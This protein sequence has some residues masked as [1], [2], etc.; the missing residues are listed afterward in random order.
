MTRIK[1]LLTTLMLLAFAAPSAWAQSMFAHPQRNGAG[2]PV[3]QSL[4]GQPLR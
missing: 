2:Q 4:S 1:F 3:L